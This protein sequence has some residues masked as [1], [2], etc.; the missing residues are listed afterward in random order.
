MSVCKVDG[1]AVA[2]SRAGRLVHLDEL[3]A[4]VDP[5][6]EIELVELSALEAEELARTNLHTLAAELIAHHVVMHPM[7]DCAFASKLAVALRVTR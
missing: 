7:S 2:E 6:H 3:P 1:V 4:G 5:D